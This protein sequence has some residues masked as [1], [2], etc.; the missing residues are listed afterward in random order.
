MDLIL[1]IDDEEALRQVLADRLE[2]EGFRVRTA[3][4]GQDGLRQ[5]RAEPPDLILCD[6]MMPG[7]DGYG[8]LSQLRSD[9][10]WAALPFIFLSAKADPPQVR[11]GM[12]L[13][14]D[15]YL[16]K[17]AS[18]ADLLA[19]IRTRLERRRQQLQ[20]L[21]QAAEVTRV[22]MVRKLPHDL[23][24]PLASLLQVGQ[25]LETVDSTKPIKEIREFGRV[26]RL[27]AQR[28]HRTIHRFLQYA[29]QAAARGQPEVQARLRG[30][31][32]I[33]TTAAA[34]KLAQQLALQ[35]S[36]QADLQLDLRELEV[37]MDPAHFGEV[38]TELVEN[39][40]K[41][42]IPGSMVLVR[43]R[44]LPD[45]SECVLEV[46][47]QGRGMTSDQVRQVG[48]F[49][50]FDSELWAQ[51]GSGL[52]LTLVQQLAALYG[53]RLTL[54]SEPGNGTRAM[55]QLPNARLVPGS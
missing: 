44:L 55:L 21:E 54:E 10:R 42:S 15:D 25:L 19:A 4:D 16:C 26:T 24:T 6:I 11:C 38:V 52:G 39:A 7:L 12:A 8:V 43:L 18:K 28:L 46:R 45:Q 30:T 32:Y 49:R 47:D 29:D 23:L 41:F 5:I 14:A 34:T 2:I 37:Q 51:A 35:D 31:R 1:I 17:P 33:P 36:R 40:L 3:A 22:E 20:Q 13:G 27:A 48:A 53:G 9:A 50:Q